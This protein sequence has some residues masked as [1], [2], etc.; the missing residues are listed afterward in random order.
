[1]PAI[2]G[3]VRPFQSQTVSPINVASSEVQKT[4]LVVLTIGGT[5]N[6]GGAKSIPFSYSH[7][8]TSYMTKQERER[9]GS[10]DLF[11]SSG[12]GSNQIDAGGQSGAPDFGTVPGFV[13]EGA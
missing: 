8:V 12:S 2:E 13:E 1:M 7:S 5:S 3:I 6:S 11:A 10:T 4:G 9:S